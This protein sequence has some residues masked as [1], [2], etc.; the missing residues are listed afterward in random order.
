MEF[1]GKRIDLP[2]FD[3]SCDRIKQA[4]EQYL[5]VNERY[6]YYRIECYIYIVP[7]T[8]QGEYETKE[9][10][11]NY[12]VLIPKSSFSAVDIDY[13]ESE[14]ENYNHWVVEISISGAYTR[15]RIKCE[16]EGFARDIFNQLSE[17]LL[18]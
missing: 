11:V 12:S 18:S 6:L 16:T 4:L 13:T 3:L 9:S 5:L 17:Y 1:T 15:L 8:K 10:Y 7:D 2:L 14:D